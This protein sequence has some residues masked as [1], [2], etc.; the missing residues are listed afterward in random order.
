M[1][2]LFMVNVVKWSKWSLVGWVQAPK[3][4]KI[5]LQLHYEHHVTEDKSHNLNKPNLLANVRQRLML[6][7][8]H[9]QTNITDIM[10]RILS[11]KMLVT[12]DV[13]D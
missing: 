9:L 13:R 1:N 7:F 5:S 2:Y 11:A 6:A 12:G 4:A 8:N 10:H 3:R